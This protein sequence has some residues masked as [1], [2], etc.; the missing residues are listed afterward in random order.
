MTEICRLLGGNEPT[1]FSECAFRRGGLPQQHERFGEIAKCAGRYQLACDE[2]D[3]KHARPGEI[4]PDPFG[5][6]DAG[7]PV[8]QPDIGDDDVGYAA[9]I[10]QDGFESR[11]R[12]GCIHQCASA[13]EQA[14]QALE[15]GRFVVTQEDV[16]ALEDGRGGVA[17]E[18]RSPEEQ[19]RTDFSAL[20]RL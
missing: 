5:D 12:L 10:G 8:A 15:N 13:E 17:Q 11:H 7:W 18:R 3:G 1:D 2:R 16:S 20:T 14:P 9:V 4:L 6:L 19:T